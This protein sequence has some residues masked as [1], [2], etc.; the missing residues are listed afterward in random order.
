MSQTRAAD[1]R[2][3]FGRN[4]KVP[5][6][7]NLVTINVDSLVLTLTL[8]AIKVKGVLCEK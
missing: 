1:K 5:C 3:L 7:H 2:R 4:L 6:T 8:E